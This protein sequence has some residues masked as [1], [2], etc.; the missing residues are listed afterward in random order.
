MSS[1]KDCREIIVVASGYFDMLHFGHIEYLEKSKQLGDK[2]IV[3]VN[4]D[5]Q[6]RLKK[7]KVL[8]SARE[9][10]QIVRALRCVDIAIESVDEDRSVCKT[11]AALHPHIFTNGGD[12]T[13]D[14]IPEASVCQALNIKMVDNLGSKIQSSSKLIERAKTIVDY[15]KYS[16]KESGQVEMAK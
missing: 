11:L 5:R 9:R 10:I 8:M 16:S 14:A 2:L 6:A 3:I 4:N 15:K 13:N 12:Q 1:S 7:G